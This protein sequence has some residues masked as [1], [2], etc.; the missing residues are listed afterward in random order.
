[1]CKQALGLLNVVRQT[2]VKFC[3]RNSAGLN[4]HYYVNAL[5]VQK[6]ACYRSKYYTN[7]VSNPTKRT[8]SVDCDYK[9]PRQAH[10][11]SRMMATW[12]RCETSQ[13]FTTILGN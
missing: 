6:E 2:N 8:R 5:Y 1:M 3:E 10:K 11:Y 12:L 13:Q 4:C 9:D 7:D